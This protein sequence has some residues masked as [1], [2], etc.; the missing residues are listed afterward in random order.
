VLLCS[1]SPN[2]LS[3][4]LRVNRNVLGDGD[5][6]IY[7]TALLHQLA[8]SDYR[9]ADQ[10]TARAKP[11]SVPLGRLVEVDRGG[12]VAYVEVQNVSDWVVVHP[13][14]GGGADGDGHGV[15]RRAKAVTMRPRP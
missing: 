14:E 6:D 13:V 1:S 3:K 12:G 11:Q 10:L 9:D 8:G 2:R 7:G 15:L 5:G 4:D